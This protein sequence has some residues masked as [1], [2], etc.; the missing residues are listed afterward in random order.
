MFE[1]DE[2]AFEILLLE[3][4]L[5]LEK[6]NKN[7]ILNINK[8]EATIKLIEYNIELPLKVEY[9]DTK[10]SDNLININY[11]LESD[12]ELTKINIIL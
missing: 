1:L 4:D 8:D 10:C 5:K 3:E 11:K 2:E 12:D 7:A 6:K 9:F